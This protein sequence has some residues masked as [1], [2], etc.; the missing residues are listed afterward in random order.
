MRARHIECHLNRCDSAGSM[1]RKSRHHPI[2]LHICD[3]IVRILGKTVGD[4]LTGDFGQHFA[5]HGIINAQYCDTIEGQ[6]VQ[7]IEECTAQNSKVPAVGFH[8]ICLYIGHDRNHR[9]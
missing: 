2:G 7:E 8:V 9:L 1:H 4:H 3:A 6:I 5:H